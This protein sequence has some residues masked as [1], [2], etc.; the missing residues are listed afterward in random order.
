MRANTMIV[1]MASGQRFLDTFLFLSISVDNFIECKCGN[2]THGS[3]WTYSDPF[4]N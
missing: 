2:T 3:G 1:V 4:Y